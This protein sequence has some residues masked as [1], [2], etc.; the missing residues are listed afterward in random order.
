[1]RAGTW[2]LGLITSAAAMV[3]HPLW[4]DCSRCLPCLYIDAT[5]SPTAQSRQSDFTRQHES[6]SKKRNPPPIEENPSSVSIIGLAQ[7]RHRHTARSLCTGGSG[8][9]RERCERDGGERNCAEAYAGCTRWRWKLNVFPRMQA[10]Y[11]HLHCT[12]LAKGPMQE[13]NQTYPAPWKPD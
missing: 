6:R 9:E 4:V 12:S 10:V 2:R 13:S 8:A 3:K 5:P 11:T 7:M 1:V